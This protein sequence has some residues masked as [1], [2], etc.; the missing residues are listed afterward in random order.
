MR[1]VLLAG[2]AFVVGFAVLAA[3][4][5]AVHAANSVTA[6]KDGVQARFI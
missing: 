6:Y 2:L 3:S 1:Q 4:V 5:P